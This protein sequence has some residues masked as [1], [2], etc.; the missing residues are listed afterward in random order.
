MLAKSAIKNQMKENAMKRPIVAVISCLL[1]A[2]F[3]V[4]APPSGAADKLWAKKVSAVTF[5]RNDLKVFGVGVLVFLI[6]T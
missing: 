1:M 2:T 3:L 4:L 6:L 5:I